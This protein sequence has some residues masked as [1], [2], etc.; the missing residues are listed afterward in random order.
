MDLARAAAPVSPR[1][2]AASAASPDARMPWTPFHVAL[3]A[4]LLTYVW[5]VQDLFPVL[6][7][8]RPAVLS[9]LAA[10]GF[11]LLGPA[12]GAGARLRHPVFRWAAVILALCALSVPGSVW[13]GYSFRFIVEDHVKTVLF[14]VLLMAAVRVPRDV[15]RFLAV[16]VAG[17]AL[18]CV[19]VLTRFEVGADGRLGGLVYY[20]ANDLAML[21]VCTLPVLV[22]FSRPGARPAMRMAAAAALVLFVVTIVRTGSRGGF[23][24][25]VAVFAAM[26]VGF[27]AVPRG[28]RL[29]AAAAVAVLLVAVGGGVYWEK[30]ATMLN[31]SQDYNWA[32]NEQTGRMEVWKRGAGYML[33]RPVFGVG[34]AAFGIAEGTISPLAARQELG[35][36]LKWSAAHNSFVQIGAELGFPGLIA[37]LLMLAAA[38]RALRAPGR[39]RAP[40]GS[41]PD[42]AALAQALTAALV[43][44]CVS[45]FFLSQAYSAYLYSLLALVAGLAAVPVVSSLPSLVSGPGRS[46][47]RPP[48]RGGLVVAAAARGRAGE[49]AWRDG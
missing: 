34:A 8:L 6:G 19:M 31:P 14:M 36:G 26:A 2:P 20:D 22:Y 3:A 11:F 29:R 13:P 28:R 45:G 23:L 27:Q 7:A 12:A 37:F 49:L 30:M 4:M 35:H 18:Y 41:V 46:R 5:R 47:A 33:Q 1:R 38:F 40:D 17:S 43:G 10:L 9:S 21:L 16:H 42:G 44:Y 48:G 25:V 39:A 32:G 15:E 24:G